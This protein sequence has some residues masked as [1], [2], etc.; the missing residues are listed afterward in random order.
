MQVQPTVGVTMPN[1]VKAGA[2]GSKARTVA[3]E[4]A[5][6]PSFRDLSWLWA[7]QESWRG[8]QSPK[9]NDSAQAAVD[10]VLSSLPM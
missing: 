9:K 1:W 8:K 4:S 10:Q 5:A 6:L 3:I 2:K 7:L